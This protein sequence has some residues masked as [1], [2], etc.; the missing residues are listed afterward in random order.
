MKKSLFV[1]SI[2]SIFFIVLLISSCDI[3]GKKFDQEIAELV[4]DLNNTPAANRNIIDNFHTDMSGRNLWANDTAFDTTEL[5]I[6]YRT[7]TIT[8]A[9]DPIEKTDGIKYQAGTLTNMGGGIGT[10]TIEF[11]FKEELSSS[12]R[13]IAMRL[14]NPVNE[15]WGTMLP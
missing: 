5:A 1:T 14:P 9:G 7:F 6:A 8:L 12:W 4:N 2:I 10:A 3:F 15:T 13:I 11:N